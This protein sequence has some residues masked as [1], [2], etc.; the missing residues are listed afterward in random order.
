MSS[1]S[2]DIF[3]N[4]SKTPLAMPHTA[5]LY[6]PQLDERCQGPGVDVTPKAA[7]RHAAII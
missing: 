5:T 2:F 7:S 1:L 3:R 6:Q 4:L